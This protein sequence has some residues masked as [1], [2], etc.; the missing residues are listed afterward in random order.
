MHWYVVLHQI[1]NNNCQI[2]Y[3]LL[4]KMN[5]SENYFE[6][7]L[8][9]PSD[10]QQLRNALSRQDAILTIQ[11]RDIYILPWSHLYTQICYYWFN[12]V[13][14]VMEDERFV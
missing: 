6:R 7:I 3:K 12:V 11:S 8:I 1:K 9:F 5:S 4:I 10:A 13:S 2:L 14:L